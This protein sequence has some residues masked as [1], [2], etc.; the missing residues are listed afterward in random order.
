MIIEDL[1]LKSNGLHKLTVI[2]Q[3]MLDHVTAEDIPN[4]MRLQDVTLYARISHAQGDYT[5]AAPVTQANK[6]NLY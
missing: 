1:T 3:P 6:V 5:L 2:K 4:L